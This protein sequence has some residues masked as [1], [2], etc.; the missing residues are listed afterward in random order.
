MDGDGLFE[1]VV[2]SLDNTGNAR[3]WIYNASSGTLKNDWQ[4]SPF[5]T[6][7][8]N[9]TV[10]VGDVNGDSVDEIVVGETGSSSP[11]ALVLSYIAAGGGAYATNFRSITAGAS[12]DLTGFLG[13]GFSGLLARV[14]RSAPNSEGGILGTSYSAV[15][16]PSI[17]FLSFAN[18]SIPLVQ[19]SLT[20]VT[21]ADMRIETSLASCSGYRL[22]LA[23]DKM[24]YR[25]SEVG[26]TCPRPDLS[27]SVRA[28][29]TDG[30]DI[31]SPTAL[32]PG[33]F[34]SY[35]SAI[36]AV[37]LNV[38]SFPSSLSQFFVYGGAATTLI[39]SWNWPSSVFNAPSFAAP[40]RN[41]NSP[42]FL[43]FSYSLANLTQELNVGIRNESTAWGTIPYSTWYTDKSTWTW[44]PSPI[45][46]PGPNF[47]VDAM[48]AQ[49]LRER[50][51]ACLANLVSQNL[52]YQHHH[53]PGW[54]PDSNAW[55][56]NSVTSGSHGS[57]MDCS[58]TTAWCWNFAYGMRF[59]AATAPQGE[60]T[61]TSVQF[62]NNNNNKTTVYFTNPQF[63]AQNYN[64]FA[65]NL[66]TGDMLY[67]KNCSSG[68][69]C[70]VSHVI[71]WLG[72]VGKCQ[73][74]FLCPS[75][76]VDSHG[77]VVVDNWNTT[78]PNGPRI[79]PFY[80][81]SWYFT[82]FDHAVRTVQDTGF[83][84]ERIPNPGQQ[85]TSAT[86]EHRPLA[87]LAA[88]ATALLLCL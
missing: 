36:N 66:E 38:T 14:C 70:S 84:Y 52:E 74:G 22:V 4:F 75:L 78:I 79:R 13:L 44:G 28:V 11:R 29:G 58:D 19:K 31:C 55:V 54:V 39:N 53:I 9:P 1:L 42:Y 33:A 24:T 21:L 16:P 57:G 8:N 82:A 40:Q 60:L 5:G 7:T 41:Y 23:T 32:P 30:P 61:S 46:F 3:V 2:G 25:A 62:N 68:P 45:Q 87:F 85:T 69:Y 72:V 12:G 59:T 34:P 47:S 64:A 37:D 43:Q 65:Q 27:L 18:T 35:I 81:G 51:V 86:L 20:D 10:G 80:P 76:I 71:S 48:P 56:W 49:W 67:I 88:I 73:S 77:Q 6:N 26:N 50:Y 63:D 15:N 17:Y 83:S